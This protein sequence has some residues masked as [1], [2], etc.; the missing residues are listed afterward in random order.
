MCFPWIQKKNKKTKNKKNPLTLAG[1]FL[2]KYLHF[3]RLTV[4]T[5]KG[6]SSLFIRLIKPIGDNLSC[7][8]VLLSQ[9]LMQCIEEAD[10]LLTAF[11]A[12]D[13]R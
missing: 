10:R 11:V 1:C 5:V 13:T 7:D 8:I 2:R 3:E 6:M 9:F 12:G 4:K